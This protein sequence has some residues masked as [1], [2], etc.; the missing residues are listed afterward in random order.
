MCVCYKVNGQEFW[1]NN[2]GVDYLFKLLPV[3]LWPINAAPTFTGVPAPTNALGITSAA[4]IDHDAIKLCSARSNVCHG[5]DSPCRAEEAQP[6]L[7]T[8][9]SK[10]NAGRYMHYS[11]A[12][13][14]NVIDSNRAAYASCISKLQSE[15]PLVHGSAPLSTLLPQSISNSL[16]GTQ[17]DCIYRV[18][19]PMR[20][21]SPI[22]CAGIPLAAS[23]VWP[24]MCS[25]TP[26]HC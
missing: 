4:I 15:M 22:A 8:D 7:M 12:R 18:Q 21:S 10:A 3:P 9:I 16:A 23:H 17:A 13:F 11:E 14:S 26:L 1:D 20:A 5:F 6:N 2:N 25:P 24:S 19:S